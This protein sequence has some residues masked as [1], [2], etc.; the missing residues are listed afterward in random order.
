[1][2]DAVKMVA[3]PK[4]QLENLIETFWGVE[5]FRQTLDAVMLDG[6]PPDDSFGS[7]TLTY[8]HAARLR[9]DN[10]HQ[11]FSGEGGRQ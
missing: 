5:W 2:S 7:I 8:P 10:R 6:S 11:L 4:E 1:M 3:V 9:P